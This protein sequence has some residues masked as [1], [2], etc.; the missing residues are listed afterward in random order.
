MTNGLPKTHTL[1]VLVEASFGAL[2]WFSA[3]PGGIEASTMP[4]V[5]MPL[6]VTV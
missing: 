5:V 3:A 1:S 2:F 6:T 4:L